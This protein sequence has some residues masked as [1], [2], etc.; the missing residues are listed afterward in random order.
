MPK[1][2]GKRKDRPKARPKRVKGTAPPATGEATVADSMGAAQMGPVSA[3][4]S[5]PGTRDELTRLWMEARRRRDSSPLGS[6]AFQQ[7][8]EDVARL[9]VEIAAVERA[10]TPPLV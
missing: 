5:L 10:M 3:R 4:P 2:E 8:C 6:D 1:D 7:A 9:E